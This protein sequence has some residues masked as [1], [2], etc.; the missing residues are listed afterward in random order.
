MHINKFQ[1]ITTN[2]LIVRFI[3]I[4]VKDAHAKR[5]VY[6]D[7]YRNR[8]SHIISSCT[9][10]LHKAQRRTIYVRSHAKIYKLGTIY[11]DLNRVRALAD[12][13]FSVLS[14]Q[15]IRFGCV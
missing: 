4:A 6:D 15:Y 7:T 11:K 5:N 14:T 1:G 13:I 3:N 9:S 10:P 8:F 12:S 2:S